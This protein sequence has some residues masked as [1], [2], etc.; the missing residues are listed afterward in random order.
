MGPCLLHFPVANH[1]NCKV[2]INRSNSILVKRARKTLC[3]WISW[4]LSICFHSN[5]RQPNSNCSNFA[6]YFVNCLLQRLWCFMYF[7]RFSSLAFNDWYFKNFDHLDNFLFVFGRRI[8]TMGHS[9]I[10][11]LNVW[12]PTLQRNYHSTILRF[13]LE[14]KDRHWREKESWVRNSSIGVWQH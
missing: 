5:G 11:L 9:R 4:E 12:N 10:R 14:H 13:R 7:V 8:L 1:A 2:W 3:L 6:Q